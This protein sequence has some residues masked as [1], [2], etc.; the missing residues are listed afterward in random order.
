MEYYIAKADRKKVKR[1]IKRQSV[2]VDD[3]S[4]EEMIIRGIEIMELEKLSVAWLNQLPQLYVQ[5]VRIIF[6]KFN[7]RNKES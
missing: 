1:K 7:E 6:D 2:F 4:Y 3:A 5:K